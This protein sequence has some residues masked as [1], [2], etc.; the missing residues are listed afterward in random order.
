MPYSNIECSQIFQKDC[1]K[2]SGGNQNQTSNSFL[3]GS[4][5]ALEIINTDDGTYP[6]EEI[7][8]VVFGSNQL[9]HR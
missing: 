3:D 5:V 9:L 7:M 6:E 2:A 4:F 8:N 1:S